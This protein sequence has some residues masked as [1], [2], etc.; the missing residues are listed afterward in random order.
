MKRPT[1]TTLVRHRDT[2]GCVC[3]LPGFSFWVLRHLAT[4]KG[5]G[6]RPKS[7]HFLKRNVLNSKCCLWR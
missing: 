7:I 4:A 1:K 2:E 6:M 3:E 5:E